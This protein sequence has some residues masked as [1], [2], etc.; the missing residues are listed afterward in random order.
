MTMQLV[1][2]KPTKTES[3]FEISNKNALS[4]WSVTIT[5]DAIIVSWTIILMEGGT[6]FRMSEMKRLAQLGEVSSDVF[7]ADCG[8]PGRGASPPR[9]D[10]SARYPTYLPMQPPKRYLEILYQS[11]EG[12]AGDRC[13]N[14]YTE[15]AVGMA[16]VI[17]RVI[18]ATLHKM[19]W[20][21]MGFAPTRE[22][23]QEVVNIS[24]KSSQITSLRLKQ[25]D[26]EEFLKSAEVIFSLPRGDLSYS[27]RASATGKFHVPSSCGT[28]TDARESG[29]EID[30]ETREG[31][32]YKLAS[33]KDPSCPMLLGRLPLLE[34]SK[35][36]NILPK[37][38]ISSKV[39]LDDETGTKRASIILR[40]PWQASDET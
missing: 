4:I 29:S 25:E 32:E 26:V 14:P 8:S 22:Q 16:E 40:L 37:G 21:A 15:M 5:R 2:I 33:F 17:R 3:C 24:R 9:D 18:S 27:T 11:V 35:A 39:L 7:A 38:A 20:M 36:P 30:N 23:K 13:I 12:A 10:P 6:L 34:T 28:R 19:Q 1:M 31:Q